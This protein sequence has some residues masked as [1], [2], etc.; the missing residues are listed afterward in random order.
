[1][2]SEQPTNAMPTAPDAT[3]AS[4]SLQRTA[5]SLSIDPAA[6]AGDL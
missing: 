5:I 2:V 3:K 4:P 6:N 1:M